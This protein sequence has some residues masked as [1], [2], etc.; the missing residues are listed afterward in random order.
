MPRLQRILCPIDFS[1]SSA[2]AMEQGIAL[3]R[4]YQARFTAFHVYS[5]IFMPVPGLPAP[6]DR[7]SPAERE[8]VRRQLEARVEAAA[9][10]GVA[11]DVIVDVGQPARQI[12]DCAARLPADLVVMGT[13]GAGGFEHLILGSVTEKVLRRAACPVLTVPARAHTRSAL[14][15]SRVLCAVDFSDWSLAALDLAGSIA[16]ESVAELDVVHVIEW[17][18][19]EP[20]GPALDEV[21]REQAGALAEYRRYV[22]QRAAARLEALIPEPLRD[23]STT[24]VQHGKAYV[25]I[26]RLAVNLRADLLVLGVHGRHAFD[27][28]LFGSTTNHIVR[29]A[30]CPVL[31]VRR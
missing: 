2:H 19:H 17:P 27:V 4:W 14:P 7:V 5:P 9:P 25:E 29:R 8:R 23:R 16:Q 1:D 11:V 20:P 10:E 18:W 22:E 26:L 13:H 6:A 15:F 30:T 24:C 3:A 12:L 28:A 31:T 21:P